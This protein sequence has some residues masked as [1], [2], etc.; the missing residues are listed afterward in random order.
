MDGTIKKVKA[1][2]PSVKTI[3]ISAFGVNDE[4]FEQCNSKTYYI[5]DLIDAV[6]TQISRL[7]EFSLR[8][9]DLSSVIQYSFNFYLFYCP[10]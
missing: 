8:T 4:V 7:A 6:E 1:T 5:P 2:N 9:K 10:Y 3:L